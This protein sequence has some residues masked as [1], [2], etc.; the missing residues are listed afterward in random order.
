VSNLVFGRD[1]S[2]E[3]MMQ[4]TSIA[5]TNSKKCGSSEAVIINEQS[6]YS[7]GTGTQRRTGKD[8][9]YLLPNDFRGELS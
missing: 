3:L 5:S 6:S 8:P 7:I 4:N 2:V 9:G 1:E